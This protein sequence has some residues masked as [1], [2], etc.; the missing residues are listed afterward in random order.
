MARMT[1]GVDYSQLQ[2]FYDKLQANFNQQ[3]CDK[4]IRQCAERIAGEL[5]TQVI[6]RTPVGHYD[7]NEYVCESGLS[8]K[9]QKVKELDGKN[10]KSGGT[11]KSHWQESEV[12]RNGN[13]YTITVYND[14]VSDDGKDNGKQYAIY[15]EYGHRKRGKGWVRGHFMLTAAAKEVQKRAPRT[16]E[17][18]LEKKLRKVFK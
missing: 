15:V 1:G 2:A 8:H 9:G 4:F 12:Q 5:K 10:I 3:E 7:G 11:L 6:K 17:R 18:M 16:L 13:S 14:A